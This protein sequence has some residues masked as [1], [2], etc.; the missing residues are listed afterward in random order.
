MYLYLFLKSEFLYLEYSLSLFCITE[1]ISMLDQSLELAFILTFL[2]GATESIS[3]M[4]LLI[5]SEYAALTHFSPKS[6][7]YTP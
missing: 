3:F 1:I 5:K 2:I 6:H 4:N 7:F